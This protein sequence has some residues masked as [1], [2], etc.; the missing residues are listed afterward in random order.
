MP[1]SVYP[2]SK[3]VPPDLP[4]HVIVSSEEDSVRM[5]YVYCNKRYF[6]TLKLLCDFLGYF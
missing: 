4:S 5:R 6:R 2:L 1:V 3:R